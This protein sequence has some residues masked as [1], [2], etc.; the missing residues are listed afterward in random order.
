MLAYKLKGRGI[1]ILLLHAFPLSSKM[2]ERELDYL[3]SD[4]QV[5]APD[6]PGF[7][8][9]PV[10][11]GPSIP[12]M[13][14]EVAQ[15][16]DHLKITEP[17][18]AGGLSMGGYVAFEFLRQFPVRVRGLGIFSSRAAPDS[19]ETREK[20]KKVIQTIEEM[21]FPAFAKKNVESLLGRTTRAQNPELVNE[22]IQRIVENRPEGATAAL[23]AMAGRRDSTDLLSS[24]RFP[25][26][27]V[28]GEEN[29]LVPP[30]EEEQLHEKISGS[31]LH[32]VAKSGHLVNLEQPAAFQ[33]IFSEFLRSKILRTKPAAA[34]VKENG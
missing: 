18:F 30:E 1:P 2:W 12:G 3:S 7:G 16:L 4:F 15:L 25:V 26:L 21:G 9:S 17:V 13:A 6:L 11:T 34:K 23:R 31:E 8:G 24:I 32:V 14:Q 33:K 5:I 29:S 28:S 19:P 22:V 27:L 20:R 10:Q